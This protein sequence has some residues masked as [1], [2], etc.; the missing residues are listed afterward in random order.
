MTG[1]PPSSGR[2][3]GSH[4]LRLLL[5][6]AAVGPIAGCEELGTAVAR[7][8]LQT[9]VQLSAAAPVAVRHLTFSSTPAAGANMNTI[10]IRV[11]RIRSDGAYEAPP[12]VSVSVRPDDRSVISW[13]SGHPDESLPGAVL[14]F[15][16]GCSEACRGGA[17]IV[18][19]ATPGSGT[20][21]DIRILSELAVSAP[22]Q[23]RR[24]LDA[25]PAIVEDPDLRFGGTPTTS[26]SA[27][28]DEIVVDS[29]TPMVRV[30]LTIHADA[31]A[32]GSDRQFPPVGSLVIH[33]IGDA[34][35]HAAL[36][37]LVAQGIGSL[38]FDA[39]NTGISLASE[40]NPTDLDWLARCPATGG[41]DLAF[42]VTIANET[43]Q[44]TA[45]GNARAA[46]SAS[47]SLPASFHLS[48]QATVIL[49]AFDG[50]TLDP[51]GVTVTL[52]TKR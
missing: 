3:R 5:F 39:G 34:P 25:A 23:D 9:D 21:D 32:L 1:R 10:T 30:G 46:G 12:G 33:G 52:E 29:A 36:S 48:L 20:T 38:L 51:G 43:L 28:A 47:P 37:S 2:R 27:A 15:A 44:S 22:S 16:R 19:R 17:T 8:Q 41:C 45:R 24:S 49:E 6:A 14:S 35:T 31:E 50:R 18:V 4:A 26:I 11:T 7:A 40:G 13:Q 42:V